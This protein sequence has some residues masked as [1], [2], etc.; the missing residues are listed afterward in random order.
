[1]KNG[2]LLLAA[3]AFAI[4][5]PQAMMAMKKDE[6]KQEEKI[7]LKEEGKQAPKNNNDKKETGKKAET[8]SLL[9][10][11]KALPGAGLACLK[12]ATNKAVGGTKYVYN[13]TVGRAVSPFVDHVAYRWKQN[14][15]GKAL[16][17]F[18]AAAA[19][20]AVVYAFSSDEDEDCE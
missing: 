11:V 14:Y 13:K 10:R 5:M 3:L 4:A 19:T 7:T 1:M 17:V 9:E 12:S 8:K 20:G 18:Y 16:V 15:Y 6:E 2:K